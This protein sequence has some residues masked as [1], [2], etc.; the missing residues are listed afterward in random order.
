MKEFCQPVVRLYL[1][2]IIEIG[3]IKSKMKLKPVMLWCS[4]NNTYGC[5]RC[6]PLQYEVYTP[7]YNM[8]RSSVALCRI[9]PPYR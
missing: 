4:W 7:Q 8:R 5:S 2:S 9:L 1:S 6:T 3:K